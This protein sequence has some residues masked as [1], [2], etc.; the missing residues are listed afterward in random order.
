MSL[1]K[2]EILGCEDLEVL[3][4]AVPEWSGEIHLRTMT[5]ADRDAFET[6]VAGTGDGRSLENIRARMLVRVICDSNGK[7]IFKDGD[8][9]ALGTRS[10]I[11]LDRLFDSA[12][13][14]NKIG[15]EEVD[16]AVEK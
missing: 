6:T 5:A 13:A 14:L 3:A 12:R 15:E 7:R 4:V 9:A 16:A 11:V 8:A 2:D 10:G 1:N